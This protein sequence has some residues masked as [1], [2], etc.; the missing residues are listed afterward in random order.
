M[1][2]DT[3]KLVEPTSAALAQALADL[4][5]SPAELKRLQNAA[6]AYANENLTWGGF[7]DSV[8]NLYT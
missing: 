5:S 6:L 3:A 4:L 7:L 1:S 8:R 2:P